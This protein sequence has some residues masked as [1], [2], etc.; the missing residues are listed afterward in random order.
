MKRPQKQISSSDV[1]AG[2]HHAL[3]LCLLKYYK[4]SVTSYLC[5]L[6]SFDLEK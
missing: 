1:N 6:L 4:S 3:S 2:V 5:V